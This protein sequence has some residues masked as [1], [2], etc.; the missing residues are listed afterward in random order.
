MKVDK[1]S[2]SDWN[3]QGAGAKA[4][5]NEGFDKTTAF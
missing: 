5:E 4:Q 3:W 1:D 2:F